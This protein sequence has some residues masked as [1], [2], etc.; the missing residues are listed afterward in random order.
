MGSKNRMTLPAPPAATHPRTD[1]FRPPEM[2]FGGCF[3]WLGVL[4]ER[5][6]NIESC[7]DG[8]LYCLF[9]VPP[10]FPY[11]EWARDEEHGAQKEA[12][13]VHCRLELEWPAEIQKQA[14]KELL[15]LF[16]IRGDQQILHMAW[17]LIC[18][19]LQGTVVICFFFLNRSHTDNPP[20]LPAL[21]LLHLLLLLVH[22]LL[23]LAP[24][25]LFLYPHLSL[26]SLFCQIFI[27]DGR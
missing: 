9:V 10:V 16:L 21:V 8:F 20:A 12:Q 26:C 5:C 27:A 13:C 2:C 18:H 3:L 7:P 23:P 1:S 11:R 25:R 22:L 14:N 4:W 19:N 24:P 15:K 17:L 6:T